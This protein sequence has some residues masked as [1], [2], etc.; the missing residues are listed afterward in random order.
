VMATHD[1]PVCVLGMEML[2]VFITWTSMDIK[3]MTKWAFMAQC[4]ISWPTNWAGL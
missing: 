3:Y 1:N 2:I 4:L